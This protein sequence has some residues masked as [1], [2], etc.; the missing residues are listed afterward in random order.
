MKTYLKLEG[1][2]GPKPQ[3]Q[4][5]QFRRPQ[6]DTNPQVRKDSKATEKRKRLIPTKKYKVKVVARPDP[7]NVTVQPPQTHAKAP[8][9][10]EGQK[11]SSENNPLPLEN[12]PVCASIPWPKVGKMSGNIFELRKDWPIPPTNNTITATNPK[13]SIKIEPQEQDQ[14][15]PNATAP[16]KPE[17]CGWGPNCPICKNAE[18]DWDGEHQKQLQQTNTKTQAQDTQQKN[19]F[20]T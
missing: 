16:P 6:P 9:N 2:L 1:K 7:N 17:Q 15:T 20:Q 18:E 19:S 11:S 12:A 8:V 14:P 13:L 5:N 3:P 10:S 4:S